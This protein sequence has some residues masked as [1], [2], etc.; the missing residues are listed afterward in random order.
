MSRSLGRLVVGALLLVVGI[1]WLLQTAGLVTFPLRALVALALIV[2]GVGLVVGSRYGR[3][4][5][6]IGLGVVLVAVLAFGSSRGFVTLRGDPE[7]GLGDRVFRPTDPDDLRSYRIDAGQLTVDL[8]RLRLDRSTTDVSA[9]V[10]AGQIVVVVPRGVPVRVESRTGVGSVEIFGE[11]RSSG[12]GVRDT[13][14]SRDYDDERPRISLALRA[15][16]GSIRVEAGVSSAR[17]T[18]PPMP[19]RGRR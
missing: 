2:V 1:A 4:P 19:Q 3:Y 10:G 11:R 6:L 12:V 13:F 17:R 18:A 7:A 8:R 9:R 15:G 16:V 5:G 14:E